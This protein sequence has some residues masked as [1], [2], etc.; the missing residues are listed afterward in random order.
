VG[1]S[2][3]LTTVNDGDLPTGLDGGLWVT[4]GW[5]ACIGDRVYEVIAVVTHHQAGF[6]KTTVVVEDGRYRRM[7][8]HK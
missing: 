2:S 1:Y 3:V 7:L 6:L 8:D 5:A 4:A